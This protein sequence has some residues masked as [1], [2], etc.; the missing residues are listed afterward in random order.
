MSALV[1]TNLL[2]SLFC[3]SWPLLFYLVLG[4]LGAWA[5]ERLHHRVS[6]DTTLATIARRFAVSLALF[7]AVG[8]TVLFAMPVSWDTKCS[9]RYCSRALGPGLLESPFPVGTPSCRAWSMCVNEYPYSPSQ[10]R[11]VLGRIKRQGC[12]AP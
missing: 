2:L 9:W 11:D 12:P 4:G 6:G 8:L 1:G 10:Y 7:S 5:G 3:G